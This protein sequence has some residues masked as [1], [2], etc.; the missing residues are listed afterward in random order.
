M[1][2]SVECIETVPAVWLS[3]THLSL[4]PLSC[5]IVSNQWPESWALLHRD[6]QQ[7]FFVSGT[8]CFLPISVCV[9]SKWSLFMSFVF[10]F[11]KLTL[12]AGKSIK[13]S[14]V[15]FFN[16][17]RNGI[18]CQNTGCQ[19]CSQ[20]FYVLSAWTFYCLTVVLFLRLSFRIQQLQI[21]Q[22]YLIGLLAVSVAYYSS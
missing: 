4:R 3:F 12:K 10:R 22:A 1:T 9:L 6:F 20:R 14:W 17:K 7:H 19:M 2:T 15:F 8:D 13:D 5:W 11:F 21:C 18:I 16:L